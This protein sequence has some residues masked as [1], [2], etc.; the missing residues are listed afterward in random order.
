M[1]ILCTTKVLSPSSF[2]VLPGY[3]GQT[4]VAESEMPL[5]MT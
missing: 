2:P 5:L 4:R 3:L 1:Y